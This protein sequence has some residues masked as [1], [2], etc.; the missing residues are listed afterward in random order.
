MKSDA[1][2]N[3]V[4]IALKKAIVSTFDDAKWRELGYLTDSIDII[5]GHPRLLRSLYWGD[6]DYEGC[7]LTV[8]PRIIGVDSEKL[9]IIEK[10]IGL[11]KWLKDNDP[12]LFAELYG[13]GEVA[14]PLEDIE[15]AANRLD[16]M[17][18]NRHAARIRQSIRDDPE[19]AIGSAKELIESIFK[20]VLKIEGEHAGEDIPALLK[21]AQKELD[22][23]PRTVGDDVPG[24]DTIRRTLSNLGQIV[25]GVAEVRNLYGTGHGRHRSRELEIAHARLVVNAAVTLATFLVEIAHER[26][27]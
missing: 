4:I 17:E 2:K 16:I 8:I 15:V 5:S 12:I 1:N 14:V 26:G 21:R 18:L 11:E 25:V 10:Y 7:V 13:T 3:K 24:K 9:E 6:D 19:Q 22:L 27:L 23:D 20:A